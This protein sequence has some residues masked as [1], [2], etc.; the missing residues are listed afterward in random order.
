MK[1]CLMDVLSD[2]CR[3]IFLCCDQITDKIT[4]M[5]LYP[6]IRLLLETLQMLRRSASSD[7][8][9]LPHL[10]SSNSTLG[11]VAPHS[12]L[13]HTRTPDAL[14]GMGMGMGTGMDM[15]ASSSM[16]SKKGGTHTHSHTHLRTSEA[17]ESLECASALVETFC[18]YAVRKYC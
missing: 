13:D 7:W 16:T 9:A 12:S 18:E 2:L 3:S 5:L 4:D 10:L 11:D 17:E 14:G 8:T 1:S 6:F 15:T